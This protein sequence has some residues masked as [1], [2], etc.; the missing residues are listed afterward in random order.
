MSESRVP[1]ATFDFRH[2]IKL[3]IRFND[4]DV[5]GHVNNAIY[6]QYYDLGKITYLRDVMGEKFTMDDLTL[7]IVNLNCN[8]YEPLHMDEPAEVLT[9]AVKIGE[10]SIVI[11]QR[12]VNTS[13]G[14][15]KSLCTTIL[16]AFDPSTGRSAPV[17]ADWR[18]HLEAFEQRSL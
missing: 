8:F 17:S 10:K 11:E 4:V 15:V 5:F 2:R 1:A 3:Q 18:A 7:L 12:V 16:A 6:F 13:T 9:G 14:H